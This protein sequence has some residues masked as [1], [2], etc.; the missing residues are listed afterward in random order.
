MNQAVDASGIVAVAIHS[1][2]TLVNSAGIVTHVLSP[3]NPLS[4]VDTNTAWSIGF[5]V[6]NFT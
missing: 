3:V 5:V 6:V 4:V 2:S 1:S